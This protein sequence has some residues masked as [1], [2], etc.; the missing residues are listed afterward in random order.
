MQGITVKNDSNKVQL[1]FIR[2]VNYPS[3]SPYIVVF[4]ILRRQIVNIVVIRHTFWERLWCFNRLFS[5]LIKCRLTCSSNGNTNRVLDTGTSIQARQL[6]LH[7]P[8][9]RPTRSGKSSTET[10]SLGDS[11]VSGVAGI[12]YIK[13]QDAI[14]TQ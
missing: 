13:N 14:Y 2:V 1:S 10:S 4:N 6:P 12:L 7:S 9:H 3:V 8:A 5:S 11:S